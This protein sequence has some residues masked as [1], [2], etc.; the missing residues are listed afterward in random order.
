MEPGDTIEERAYTEI[1]EETG[2]CPGQVN[3][4]ARGPPIEFYDAQEDRH[5]CVH[6][7]LFSTTTNEISIDWEHETYMWTTPAQ[8]DTFKTV[9]KLKETIRK[10][11]I[12]HHFSL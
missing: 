9:P 4:I 2:L 10:M 11:L 8:L 1:Y 3:L 5:R 6:P 12:Q 7:F